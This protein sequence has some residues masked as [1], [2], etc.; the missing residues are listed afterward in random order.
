[1]GTYTYT[2]RGCGCR[3]K[4]YL[5][6]RMNQSTFYK[7]Q[8]ESMFICPTLIIFFFIKS[9]LYTYIQVY[10]HRLNGKYETGFTHLGGCSAVQD[11]F[12]NRT[13]RQLSINRQRSSEW[14][15]CY[16]SSEDEP[17]SSRQIT[18]RQRV[19][20]RSSVPARPTSAG[21]RRKPCLAALHSPWLQL[22][23]NVTDTGCK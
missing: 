13:G 23:Y 21:E 9:I 14:C 3:T 15:Q 6:S 18:A 11:Q 5:V 17:S 4:N 10:N 16:N 20:A 2:G 1:M 19:T 12:R 8:N 22:L 7:K